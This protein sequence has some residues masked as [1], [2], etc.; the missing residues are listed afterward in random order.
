MK[1]IIYFLQNFSVAVFFVSLFAFSAFAQNLQSDLSRTFIKYDLVRLDN[2]AARRAVENRQTVSIRAAGKTFELALTPRDLRSAGYRAEDTGIMGTHEIDASAITTFKGK[3]S[4]EADSEVRLAIDDRETEG[5]FETGGKRFFLEPAQRFSKYAAADDLIVYRDGDLLRDDIACDLAEKLERGQELVASE[6]AASPQ[7]FRV[8][9]I[10]TD[11]DFQYLSFFG[12]SPDRVNTEILNILNM[13][14]GVYQHE[15]GLT[16]NVVYQHTWTTQDPYT[17]VDRPTLLTSFQNYW[18]ANFPP[19]QIPRDT[20]HLFT[21]KT[22]A[23][24]GGYAYIGVICR[25]PAAAYGLSGYVDFESG[26]VL[27]TTHEIGHN[28]GANHVDATQGCDNTIMNAQLTATTP[29]TFCDY[30]RAEITNYVNANGA[31]LSTQTQTRFDFDGDARADLSIF[32]PA[33]GEWWYLRSSDGQNRA[34]QF[35]SRTDI[36]APADYTGDGR[37]DVALFRPSTGEWFILRS[38]DSSFYSFPFGTNGDVPA[39]GDYDGDGKADAAVFRSSTAT[40]FIM[41]ST[42]GT[43]I[44]QF[45]VIGDVPVVADYDNDGRNDIAVFRPATGEW[46]L[47]RSRA[48]LIAFQ[49]GNR[50]DKPVPGDYTGDGAADVAIFRPSTGEWFVLRSENQSFYSFPFGTNGDIPAPADYDGDGK[51]DAAVFRPSGST[52]FVNK[53]TGGALIQNFGVTGDKPVPSA[54]IP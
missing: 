13:A 46:W 22:F 23:Q 18:N 51:F 44:Q 47:L 26:R 42:G 15:L 38:E 10:A 34:F 29:L 7:A 25:N 43:T 21:G 2:Q 24:G 30:S 36:L 41:R 53:S 1:K 3:I 39:P 5:Y 6:V 31:C 40:W 48:G 54:F 32:R 9:E 19:S 16:L 35:G 17:G 27:V 33:T 52:W 37:T 12:N 50:S 49:F 4:G 11:A 14:E 28:L 20:A 8:I 45:G